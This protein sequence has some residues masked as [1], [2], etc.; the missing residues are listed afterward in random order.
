VAGEVGL[1]FGGGDYRI[2]GMSEESRVEI[3][4]DSRSLNPAE[5]REEQNRTREFLGKDQERVDDMKAQRRET[6]EAIGDEVDEEGEGLKDNISAVALGEIKANAEKA[7]V[8]AKKDEDKARVIGA[9]AVGDAISPK[10]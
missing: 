7:A 9:Q 10:K 1:I 8:K 5:I 6:A 2:G 4:K 3:T